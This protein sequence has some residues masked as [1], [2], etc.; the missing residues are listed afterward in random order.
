MFFCE[1][2]IFIGNKIIM[3]ALTDEHTMMIGRGKSA[4]KSGYMMQPLLI[5]MSMDVYYFHHS[6]VK[7]V[8]LTQSTKVGHS[9][10]M[11]VRSSSHL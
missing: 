3:L 4:K 5:M 2:K 7:L 1:I 9:P 6:E 11:L 10:L 8:P